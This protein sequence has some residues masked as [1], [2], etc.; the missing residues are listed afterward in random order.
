[1]QHVLGFVSYKLGWVNAKML[2]M[3]AS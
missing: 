3:E 2:F 1:M